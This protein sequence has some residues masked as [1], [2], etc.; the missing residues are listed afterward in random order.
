MSLSRVPAE[1]C[2][3]FGQ[4]SPAATSLPAAA[5]G[6][7]ERE[8]LPQIGAGLFPG[9]FPTELEWA[10]REGL[11]IMAESRDNGRKIQPLFRET[12]KVPRAPRFIKWN[13]P[14]G[15]GHQHAWPAF[16]RNDWN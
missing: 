8:Q 6:R 10:A 2:D 3:A 7:A 15:D 16:N 11:I 4:L 14:A 1:P 12:W 5:Q 9:E 13:K